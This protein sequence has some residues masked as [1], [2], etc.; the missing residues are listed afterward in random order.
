M[1]VVESKKWECRQALLLS[2]EGNKEKQQQKIKTEHAS[3]QNTEIIQGEKENFEVLLLVC[4]KC[5]TS[6]LHLYENINGCYKRKAF[7]CG[8]CLP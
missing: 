5:F 3:S 1:N 6:F 4:L 7:P 8:I 2:A